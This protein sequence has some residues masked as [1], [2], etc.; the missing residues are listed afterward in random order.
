[1]DYNP[2]TPEK[3]FKKEELDSSYIPLGEFVPTTNRSNMVEL[4]VPTFVRGQNWQLDIPETSISKIE[5][6]PRV[7][8]TP[9]QEQL[10]SISMDYANSIQWSKDK[11]ARD[12]LQNFYDGHGQTLDGVRLSAEVLPNGRYKVR[13]VGKGIYSPDKAI[14]LGET[15]KRGDSDAAGNYGEGLKMTVLKI[16]KDFGAKEV[17]TGSD[18][19]RVAFKVGKLVLLTRKC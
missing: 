8:F 3:Y 4:S 1:M 16:L 2:L 14:Y 12:I 11:I 10:T 15:T 7:K 5:R 9:G 6:Q 18:N 13:I 17:V 19:W